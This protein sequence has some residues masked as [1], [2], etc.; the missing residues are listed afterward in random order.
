MN[1]QWHKIFSQRDRNRTINT[2]VTEAKRI[3]RW[4]CPRM[5]SEGARWN[6][7]WIL[8]K[9][10]LITEAFPKCQKQKSDY[11]WR[12]SEMGG[13]QWGGGAAEG[14]SKVPGTVIDGR[15]TTV[16]VGRHRKAKRTPGDVR[17]L[18]SILSPPPASQWGKTT[19][20]PSPNCGWWTPRDI[21][22]LHKGTRMNTL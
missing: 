19:S 16:T 1:I 3:K 14:S 9:G 20:A 5:C 15:H 21:Q 17:G 11:K 2:G 6:G 13:R 8:I 18:P 10:K 4:E 7:N 22:T 12:R